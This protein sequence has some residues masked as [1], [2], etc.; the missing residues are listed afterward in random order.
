MSKAPDSDHPVRR[1]SS[2]TRADR[3]LLGYAVLGAAAWTVVFFD[4][5]VAGIVN[6]LIAFL[7]VGLAL[8]YLANRADDKAHERARFPHEQTDTAA[9]HADRERPPVRATH[10]WSR[11]AAIALLIVG[12]V[13][14]LVHRVALERKQLDPEFFFSALAAGL[15]V[16]LIVRL[17]RSEQAASD[18]WLA[19]RQA[20]RSPQQVGVNVITP[21][22]V[23]PSTGE[24]IARRDSRSRLQV[25]SERLLIVFAVIGLPLS[26]LV[27][28]FGGGF[29]AYTGLIV[30]WL[31]ALNRM[32]GWNSGGLQISNSAAEQRRTSQRI[33]ATRRPWAAAPPRLLKQMRAVFISLVVIGA[34]AC[35]V[36][37]F[38][39]GDSAPDRYRS[40][41]F[42]V[43]GFLVS[44]VV[45]GVAEHE[46]RRREQLWLEER[47][48]DREP[49]TSL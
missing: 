26:M 28:G 41:L 9:Q 8:A 16:Y 14:M 48:D 11:R 23:H 29:V 19:Q 39:R 49:R 43:V 12:F 38:L 31:G 47:F 2:L 20:A 36:M 10:R 30:V 24:R 32:E 33:R 5:T 15:A 46:Q 6:G 1:R 35:I 37:P 44:L 22:H 40:A 42:F 18:A 4:G 25:Y 27:F 3:F 34:I 45:L 7:S 13:G 17:D 21:L